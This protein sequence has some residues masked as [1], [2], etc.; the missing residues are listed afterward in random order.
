MTDEEEFEGPK[1][2]DGKPNDHERSSADESETEA[3]EKEESSGRCVQCGEQITFISGMNTV[4]CVHVMFALSVCVCARE[5]NIVYIMQK[6]FIHWNELKYANQI[7]KKCMN[8]VRD[9]GYMGSDVVYDELRNEPTSLH[10]VSDINDHAT[11][12]HTYM[13]S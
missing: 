7:E 12:S 9:V 4:S 8:I 5:C 6:V 10:K 3:S 2:G 13:T 11:I 1:I